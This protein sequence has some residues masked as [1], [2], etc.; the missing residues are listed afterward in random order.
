MTAVDA[1]SARLRLGVALRQAR[2]G[3]GYTIAE[4]AQA[5]GWS[6]TKV[7]RIE[8][9][10]S[11]ASVTDLRALL[12]HFGVRDAAIRDQLE[13]MAREGRMPRPYAAFHR[14]HTVRE[15]TFVT[16]E[17][18]AAR[19]RV[20]EHRMVPELLR[21]DQYA[22][23]VAARLEPR[24][25]PQAREQRLD[26]L[27]QRQRQVLDR[28]DPPLL[29]VVLDEAVL[30]RPAGDGS[31]PGSVLGEQVAWLRE[32]NSRPVVTVL[33]LPMRVGV[34]PGLAAPFSLLNLPD[35]QLTAFQFD[36]DGPH[37]AR[38]ATTGR[39]AAVFADLAAK[40]RTLDQIYAEQSEVAAS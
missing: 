34:H 32:L 40:A 24:L 29:T 22:H 7:L 38:A 15:R 28:R 6:V 17:A 13:V 20:Y 31:G 2:D 25:A 16:Q 26:L 39:Y 33:V 30:G 1:T 37:P 9:G 14:V 27:R 12:Q 10:Q 23:A 35:G 36:M 5:L 8:A 4:V 19:L 21:T 3:A 11:G 18:V